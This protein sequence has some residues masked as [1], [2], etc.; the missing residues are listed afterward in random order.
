MGQLH[1]GAELW[2]AADDILEGIAGEADGGAVVGIALQ[3][4]LGVLNALKILLDGVLG[5][6]KGDGTGQLAGLKDGIGGV[7]AGDERAVVHR[8]LVHPVDDRGL[9]AQSSHGGTHRLLQVIHVQQVPTGNVHTGRDVG[10]FPAGLVEIDGMGVLVIN[11]HAEGELVQGAGIEKFKVG[12]PGQ[13]KI[14]L[15]LRGGE[16]QIGQLLSVPDKAAAG[17]GRRQGQHL[18]NFV[19]VFHPVFAHGAI[20]QGSMLAAPGQTEKFLLGA[21]REQNVE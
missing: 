2:T 12:V 1:G 7:G 19:A 15:P 9:S 10:N 5:V 17:A 21:D 6:L 11:L 20:G 3:G 16:K 8:E 18:G 14:L 4:V 13:Q